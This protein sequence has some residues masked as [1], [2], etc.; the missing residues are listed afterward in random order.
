MNYDSTQL[1]ETSFSF[2]VFQDLGEK[3]KNKTLGFLKEM[4]TAAETFRYSLKLASQPRPEK[5]IIVMYLHSFLHLPTWVYGK[6]SLLLPSPFRT[7]STTSLLFSPRCD[8][9][10]CARQQRPRNTCVCLHNIEKQGR[11]VTTEIIFVVDRNRTWRLR[12]SGASCCYPN[13]F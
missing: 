10:Q 5:H 6:V 2:L 13:R 8:R 4:K 7:N 9:L 11:S 3:K 12:S 1:S